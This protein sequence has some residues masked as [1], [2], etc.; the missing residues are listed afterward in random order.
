[1]GKARDLFKK[2]K[3]YQ[4]NISCKDGLNKGHK[5]YGSNKAESQQAGKF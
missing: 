1:M 3:R 5:L 2:S 4:G